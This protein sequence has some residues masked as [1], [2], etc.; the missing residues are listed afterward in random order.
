MG[1]NFLS[2]GWT[3]YDK[4]LLYNEIDVTEAFR[5]L[6]RGNVELKVMLGN[7]MYNVPTKGYHKLSGSCGAPKLLFCLH[8]EYE[9]GTSRTIVSDESWQARRGPVTFSSIYAGEYYDAGL[10][11]SARPA[12]LTAPRWDVPL[13]KQKEGS[14]VTVRQE[15]PAQK[16][17]DNI[18]DFRQN[19]SGIVRI[20]VKGPKGSS[21]SLRPAE[22][23]KNGDISQRCMPGYEWK[24]TLSG[25]KR[26]ETWQPQ[27]SYTGFRYV[28]VNAD[29]GV[30]LQ[31]ITALHTS[32]D[33]AE[34]GSFRCSDSLYNNIHS[35]IDWAIRSN[36]VSI[37]T[38]CPT[39][40]KLGWLEQLHLMEH[41]MQY[42]YDVLPLMNKIIDD[43]ADSQ[44]TD[45]AIPTT[46]PEYTPFKVGSGFE[47]TPEWGASFILCPWYVYRWYGD[48]SAMRKHYDNMKCYAN[49][50]A[51]R[52]EGDI[53]NY[54]LGDW[55]DVGP[56]KPGKAQLT[57]V[58]LS[59]TAMYHYLL[60][61]MSSVAAHLGKTDD[62]DF[63]TRKAERVKD[64]FGK[65]FYVGGEKIY[66][67]GS[68]A[69]LS[70]ALYMG[71]V[72]DSL[73][74]QTVDALIRDV[75]SHGYAVTAG[76]IGYRYVLQVLQQNNLSSV[77][78]MMNHNDA[79]PGYAYQL[80]KGATALT[81]SWQAYDDV[82]NNHM[83]LGH[84]MEWLYGGLGGIRQENGS[85]G[86]K[87]I[88]IDPQMV[89]NVT[90]AETS[91]RTPLGIV[92]CKWN[93]GTDRGSWT[94]DITIPTGSD[95]TVHCP[96]G[97]IR[98]LPAGKY[99]LGK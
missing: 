55:F 46:A 85:I 18:Y 58:A 65:R 25:D 8:L 54:G 59:A 47:D 37:S 10:E 21:I 2:P 66:E 17:S 91:L 35:L 86:W 36:L 56:G 20:R 24:Y 78:D 73:K 49:Y 41:S 81:E 1:D 87:H 5:K 32:T 79:I 44:H 84:L 30:E 39:R 22:I 9:D 29:E 95:A 28:A 76:D 80:K 50:L 82:S 77:I 60:S 98:H 61:T 13:V 72:P 43:I 96:D 62:A 90:W 89:D 48:D 23:L 92:E 12:V 88:V 70:M 68:Q 11:S 64:A 27:F 93:K 14:M 63:F 69:A 45:G 7:G 33:A 26:G 15:L 74:Q 4:A 42:R 94:M 71:L 75:K 51:S 97:T 31:E 19:S 6:S 53:L 52:T 40:E 67:N 83:M 3:K 99:H 34:A 57:S 38:D 16:I